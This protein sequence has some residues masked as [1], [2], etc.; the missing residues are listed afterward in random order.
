MLRFQTCYQTT[1]LKIKIIECE[2]MKSAISNFNT[3]SYMLAFLFLNS[4]KFDVACSIHP[5]RL[6]FD[7]K[8][9]VITIFTSIKLYP[10]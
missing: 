3:H 8:S 1:K 7:I 4:E 5:T 9:R 2:Y 10:Y 6:G